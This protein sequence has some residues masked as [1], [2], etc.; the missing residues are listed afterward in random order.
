[1][2]QR[3]HFSQKSMPNKAENERD[4]ALQKYGNVWQICQGLY[5][6]SNTTA[7]IFFE[8]QETETV[9]GITTAATKEVDSKD[10]GES[11]SARIVHTETTS[12]GASKD[13]HIVYS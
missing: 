7:N 8:D 10:Y 11:C 12:R 9:L 4:L 13:L 2:L 5:K 6:H 1:M 3:A